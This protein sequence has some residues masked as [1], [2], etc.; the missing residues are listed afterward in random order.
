MDSEQREKMIQ[1]WVQTNNVKRY[2]HGERP[3]GETAPSISAWGRKLKTKAEKQA[4]KD[5]LV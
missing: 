5:A 2:K 1:D 3:S 4:A